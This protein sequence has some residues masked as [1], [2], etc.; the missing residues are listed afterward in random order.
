MLSS[1]ASSLSHKK[2]DSGLEPATN[3]L[4]QEPANH[5]TDGGMKVDNKGRKD[6]GMVESKEVLHRVKLIEM[7]HKY[8]LHHS[9]EVKSKKGRRPKKRFSSLPH[10]SYDS[11]GCETVGI[12]DGGAEEVGGGEVMRVASV[13]ACVNETDKVRLVASNLYCEHSYCFSIA[14]FFLNSDE[15]KRSKVVCDDVYDNY[16][17][18]DEVFVNGVSYVE[19]DMGGGGMVKGV[20]DVNGGRF[21]REYVPNIACEFDVEMKE[22]TKNVEDEDEEEEGEYHS[23]EKEM[24]IEK[25]EELKKKKRKLSVTDD[26]PKNKKSKLQRSSN[27]SKASRELANL[28][29]GA[30]A[31]VAT[32]APKFKKRDFTAETK[33]LYKIVTECIDLED[34]MYLERQFKVRYFVNF[35][36]LSLFLL[37]LLLLF[38]LFCCCFFIFR[39]NC[40][41]YSIHIIIFVISQH[42]RLASVFTLALS[43]LIQAMIEDSEA[44][45]WVRMT[46]WGEYSISKQAGFPIIS[47]KK[48]T[49]RRDVVEFHKTGLCVVRVVLGERGDYDDVGGSDYD[50]V[51]GSVVKVYLINHY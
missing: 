46:R 22:T 40:Y 3:D 18:P 37:F 27:T 15:L 47:P 12:D 31:A 35:I 6:V 29:P 7:D 2:V 41:S 20:V 1:V 10:D 11:S 30:V 43:T 28:L 32:K 19:K 17:T 21:V 26:I 23:S 38:L 49:R 50:D 33:V 24:K 48:K 34:A 8:P 36:F 39:I 42:H 4:K 14:H 13:D 45:A 25:F 51:D 5:S 16:S 44:P 9:L